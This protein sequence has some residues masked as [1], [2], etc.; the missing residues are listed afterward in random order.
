MLIL[1]KYI[2]M[3]VEITECSTDKQQSQFSLFVTEKFNGDFIFDTI[4]L[5]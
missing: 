1:K 5:V 3:A 2:K 4:I